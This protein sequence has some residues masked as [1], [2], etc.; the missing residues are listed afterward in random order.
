MQTTTSTETDVYS[1]PAPVRWTRALRALSQVLAHPEQTDQVLVFSTY[2]NAGSSL[3]RLDR[4][5]GDPR[6][7]ALFD[8]KRA[9][10]SH[11]VDLDALA[12]LPEGTLGHAYSHFMRSHAPDAR[13]L[14]RAADRCRRSAR[15][16]RDPAYAPDARPVARGDQRA[17]RPGRRGRAAGV[18]LRTG[19]RAAPD[20]L[21]LS[22][23]S[24]PSVTTPASCATSS[25][26][27]T[28][29]P[30]RTARV[31]RMEDHWST[32]LVE[33]RR[34]LGL[35]EQPRPIGGYT[36]LAFEAA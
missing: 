24:R 8:R 20:S 11:T 36:N 34:L 4:F 29:P 25:R 14:R 3:D 31:V 13:H 9:I 23:R 21:P 17:D 22:A 33:V 27:S 26:C 32:P 15:S 19:R 7:Q 30:R 5:F 10:D 18:H 1:L 2:A 16:V 12:R 28:R 35:P 6:G